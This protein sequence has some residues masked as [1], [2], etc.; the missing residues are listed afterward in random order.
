LFNGN[1]ILEK[2]KKTF[3]N[4]ILQLNE[5]WQLNFQLKSW[6]AQPS[7]NNAWLCGFVEGDGGFYTNQSNSFYL[8]KY[9]NGTARYGFSLKFYITQYDEDLVLLKIRDLFQA[10]NQLNS[11]KNKGSNNLYTR[12]EISQAKSRSLVI[13]YFNRF[14]MF[15]ARQIDFLRWVRI[16]DY[17][18]QGLRFSEKSAKKL[19]TLLDKLAENDLSV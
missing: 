18:Q 7:L 16:H 3:E 19:Q 15:G 2:R 1:L 5:N 4:V 8:G 17:Q 14:P 11:F 12:L 10:T 6:T 9:T 13:D